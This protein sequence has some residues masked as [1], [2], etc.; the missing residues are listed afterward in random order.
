MC[1]NDNTI[2]Y[3]LTSDLL[4]QQCSQLVMI[5]EYLLNIGAHFT[6]VYYSNLKIRE[7]SF[8]IFFILMF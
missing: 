5:D 4:Y 6:K 7:I 8:H 2:Y 1:V 3:I